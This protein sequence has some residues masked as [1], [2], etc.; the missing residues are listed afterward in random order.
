MTLVLMCEIWCEDVPG[1]R[2][3][4][5]LFWSHMLGEDMALGTEG[6]G[7]VQWPSCLCC[8]LWTWASVAGPEEFGCS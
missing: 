8:G 2:Q 3:E 4:K 5:Q 6:S 1:V 7:Q